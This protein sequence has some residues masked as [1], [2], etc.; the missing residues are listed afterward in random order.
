MEV[1]R[2][3]KSETSSHDKTPTHSNVGMDLKFLPLYL[4]ATTIKRVAWGYNLPPTR[5][6][7]TSLQLGHRK[8]ALVST[9]PEQSLQNAYRASA[10][11]NDQT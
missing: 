3:N 9:S 4:V 6:A 2:L 10:G 7:L 11:E 1:V 8:T 5:R